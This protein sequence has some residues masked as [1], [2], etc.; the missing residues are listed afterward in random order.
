MK[1]DKNTIFVNI[2]TILVISKQKLT[3]PNKNDFFRI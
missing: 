1:V 2:Q 3:E